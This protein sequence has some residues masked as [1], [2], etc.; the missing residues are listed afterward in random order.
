MHNYIS[1]SQ[2]SLLIVTIS[3]TNFISAFGGFNIYNHNSFNTLASR[4]LD[5]HSF[6]DLVINTTSTPL[7]ITIKKK[8]TI[9][10]VYSIILLDY[11]LLSSQFTHSKYHDS[12]DS[13][14]HQDLQSMDVPP[15]F[16]PSSPTQLLTTAKIPPF[17][18]TLRAFIIT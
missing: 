15:V 9:V 10:S 7:V 3:N 12:S 5:F 8:P 13:P 17:L 4:V 16:C 14:P 18:K 1:I 11:H 2:K 6:S